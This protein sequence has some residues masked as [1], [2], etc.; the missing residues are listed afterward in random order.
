MYLHR[1][2]FLDCNC[3]QLL[4]CFSF[5]FYQE[6]HRSIDGVDALHWK[7]PKLLCKILLHY[8]RHHPNDIALLFQLLRATTARYLPDFQVLL[9]IQNSQI[10][11]HL[12]LFFTLHYYH[13]IVLVPSRFLGKYCGTKLHCGLEEASILQICRNLPPTKSL[14]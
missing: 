13:S 1:H 5:L 2:H 7:E 14:T 6:T 11:S 9:K 3:E 4:P 10:L 8:F 12:I